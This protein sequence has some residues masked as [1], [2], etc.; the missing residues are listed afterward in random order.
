MKKE[1]KTYL[2]ADYRSGEFKVMKLDPIKSGKLA[3]FEIPIEI[4]INVEIPERRMMKAEGKITLSSTKIKGMIIA[5][6]ELEDEKNK[7]KVS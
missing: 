7:N 6:M 4:K 2:I 5:G 3:P 1:L